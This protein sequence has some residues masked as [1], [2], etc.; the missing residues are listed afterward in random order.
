MIFFSEINYISTTFAIL[1]I[2]ASAINFDKKYRHNIHVV[3]PIEK[4][5]RM[6]LFP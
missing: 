4:R 2:S 1:L 5:V 6:S 3:F